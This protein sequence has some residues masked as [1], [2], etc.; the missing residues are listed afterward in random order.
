VFE[1]VGPPS[2][3]PAEPC[4]DKRFAAGR[5]HAAPTARDKPSLR[6]ERRYEAAPEKVWRAWTDPQAL[7]AW[8]GP[9]EANS[10]T[11]AE[12]DLRV[13]GQ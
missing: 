11:L 8:F 5:R 1:V 7:T 12:V 3:A 13:G 2:A 9:G 4:L 10:V 6:L